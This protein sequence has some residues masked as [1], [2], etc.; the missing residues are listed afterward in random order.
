MALIGG[1]PFFP[2][3]A[4]SDPTVVSPLTIEVNIPA[5]ELTLMDQGQ[6]VA[7]YPVAIGQ[8][9]Y[10]SIVMEGAIKT[11]EW[12]PAWYPPNSP[13]A[14][15]EKIAPPGPNNPL[16]PVKMPINNEIRIHGTNKDKSVGQLASHGCFRMHN[17]DAVKLGW[18]LQ[19]HASDQIDETLLQ[20]YTQNRRRTYRVPLLQPVPVRVIY[21]P[22]LVQNEN[23]Q[24]YPDVYGKV[25]SWEEKIGGLLQPRGIAIEWLNQDRVSQVKQALKR[26]PLV[27]RIADLLEYP[28]LSGV[29]VN[30]PQ[31]KTV[32]AQVLQ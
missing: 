1:M 9:A 14:R 13:W 32:S 19:S 17:E 7:R 12:N 5:R 31:G 26:T 29:P 4:E 24:L 2:L 22:V 27:I 8:L 15:G 25:K 10:R 30:S 23:L 28:A 11:V 20:T 3:H 21:E 18:Y 6:V 16:G